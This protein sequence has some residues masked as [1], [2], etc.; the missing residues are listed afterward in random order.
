MLKAIMFTVS[1]SRRLFH[2]RPRRSPCHSRPALRQMPASS[3]YMVV[4]DLTAIVGLMVAAS[5]A[6]SMAAI[7]L[8]AAA[9]QAGT[10]DPM[11]AIAGLTGSTPE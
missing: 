6:G 3:W 7:F 5:P 11:A 9:R 1:L 4:A 8:G 2:W 10:S